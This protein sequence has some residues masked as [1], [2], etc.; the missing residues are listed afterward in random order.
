MVSRQLEGK[1]PNKNR[2][3]VSVH[4]FSFN[5]FFEYLETTSGVL[6]H[7]NQAGVLS[8][9]SCR[10]PPSP[11]SCFLVLSSLK[12]DNFANILVYIHSKPL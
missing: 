3:K 1:H 4:P 11:Q 6:T 5:N 2:L 10:R 12:F 8:S 9:Q 7:L